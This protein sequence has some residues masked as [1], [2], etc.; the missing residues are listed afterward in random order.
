MPFELIELVSGTVLDDT[1]GNRRRLSSRGCHGTAGRMWVAKSGQHFCRVEFGIERDDESLAR[2]FEAALGSAELET[3]RRIGATAALAVRPG[4]GP[5][6]IF[7][8]R[9]LPVGRLAVVLDE[10]GHPRRDSQGAVASR[11]QCAM[12]SEC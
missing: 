10:I 8:E 11:N 3:D 4:R 2:D 9:I 6:R 1:R 12:S 5:A 7:K